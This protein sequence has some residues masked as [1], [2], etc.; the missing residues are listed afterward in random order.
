MTVTRW[1]FNIPSKKIRVGLHEHEYCQRGM[2]VFSPACLT[3][4]PLGFI[5]GERST[6]EPLLCACPEGM[7]WALRTLFA[8]TGS[9]GMGSKWCEKRMENYR[10]YCINGD[11]AF[12]TPIVR[13]LCMWKTLEKLFDEFYSFVKL[14]L[15]LYAMFYICYIKYIVLQSFT[16]SSSKIGKMFIYNCG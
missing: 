16:W 14:L 2:C 6:V 1:H 13:R 12:N 10:S 9:P 4:I 3:R 15:L 8:E 5:G 7:L 11:A